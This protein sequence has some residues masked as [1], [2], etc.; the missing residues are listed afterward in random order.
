MSLRL[1]EPSI[2]AAVMERTP[3]SAI[4]LV[5]RS[6]PAHFFRRMLD[7][8]AVQLESSLLIELYLTWTRL[9][10]VNTGH[11]LKLRAHEFQSSFRSLHKALNSHYTSIA[12]LASE[13]KYM[14]C[15]LTQMPGLGDDTDSLEESDPP[16][17][18]RVAIE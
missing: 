8:L 14:L 9:L 6:L 17:K 1:N 5:V 11:H 4:Q 2:I 7:L 16:K 10:L 18:R 3:T 15:C 12:S 13:S